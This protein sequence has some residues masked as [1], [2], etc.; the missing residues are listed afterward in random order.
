M[1]ISRRREAAEATLNWRR[2]DGSGIRKNNDPASAR[3]A[4]WPSHPGGVTATPATAGRHT[5]TSRVASTRLKNQPKN[6]CQ[7]RKKPT[8]RAQALPVKQSNYPDRSSSGTLSEK[9]N[10]VL[11][12]SDEITALRTT[13]QTPLSRASRSRL[14]S[15]FEYNYQ[16]FH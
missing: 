7:T 2:V 11:R 15:M 16:F 13:F 1:K 8:G 3:A 10:L 14:A 9:I 5:K 4:R 6:Y 12:S